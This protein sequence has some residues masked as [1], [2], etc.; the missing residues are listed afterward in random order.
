MRPRRQSACQHKACLGSAA[1]IVLECAAAKVCINGTH[2]EALLIYPETL[3]L[4]E[5]PLN[6]SETSVHPDIPE[7]SEALS[8]LS[9][10]EPPKQPVPAQ[11]LTL[12]MTNPAPANATL[13]D[14][15]NGMAAF[16]AHVTNLTTQLAQVTTNIN[17]MTGTSTAL[18]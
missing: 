2:D 1:F 18:T 12:T 8:P 17:N 7:P 6:I 13:Q 3:Q 9:I 11:A 5:W 10:K 16:K 4:L 15:L 14:L